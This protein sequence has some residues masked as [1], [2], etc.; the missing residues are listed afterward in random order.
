MCSVFTVQNP[1]F[2]WKSTVFEVFSNGIFFSFRAF[3]NVNDIRIL[4]LGNSD[5]I[6]TLSQLRIYFLKI[7]FREPYQFFP[8]A[9][10]LLTLIFLKILGSTAGLFFG[11]YIGTQGSTVD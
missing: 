6:R 3:F 1:T 5:Y 7:S 10:D 8:E 11:H 2:T 4:S 9:P